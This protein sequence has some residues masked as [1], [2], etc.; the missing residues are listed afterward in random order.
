MCNPNYGKADE[1]CRYY[2]E[3]ELGKGVNNDYICV[4]KWYLLWD[5]G[6]RCEDGLD[7]AENLAA[8]SEVDGYSTTTLLLALGFGSGLGALGYLLTKKKNDY[9]NLESKCMVEL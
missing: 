8:Y 1:M 6:G 3:T 4:K 9:K 2:A 7:E 5:K